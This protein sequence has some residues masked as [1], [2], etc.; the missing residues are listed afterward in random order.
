MMEVSVL[1]IIKVQQPIVGINE[2]RHHQSGEETEIKFPLSVKLYGMVA[3]YKI[4]RSRKKLK[5][6]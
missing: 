1:L 4:K 2:K 6:G 3:P 5:Y